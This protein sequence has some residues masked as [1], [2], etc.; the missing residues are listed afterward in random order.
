MQ[1]YMLILQDGDPRHRS[2]GNSDGASL[3]ADVRYNVHYADESQL[4]YPS[5]QDAGSGAE[6]SRPI[7]VLRFWISE[8]LTQAE[9]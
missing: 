7:S 5:G 8:G 1:L 9:S 4:I 3:Q 2:S 6:R